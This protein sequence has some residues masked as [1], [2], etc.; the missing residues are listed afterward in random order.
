MKR[1]SVS[2]NAKGKSKSLNKCASA[3]LLEF[4]QGQFPQRVPVAALTAATKYFARGK[5]LAK[6]DRTLRRLAGDKSDIATSSLL[7]LLSSPDTHERGKRL[8]D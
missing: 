3:G 4:L 8:S 6:D 2:P 1:T 7:D 5:P